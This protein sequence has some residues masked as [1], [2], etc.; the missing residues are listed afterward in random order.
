MLG[1]V[2]MNRAFCL[3]PI[4]RRIIET[5]HICGTFEFDGDLEKI[6]NRMRPLDPRDTRA[7]VCTL[8]GCSARL[9]GLAW[10]ALLQ[11]ERDPGVS[12]QM[13]LGAVAV[14]VQ[15]EPERDGA[16]FESLA[17]KFN[18]AHRRCQ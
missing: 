18:T 17:Q 2:R 14:S 13:E 3:G 15:I 8:A 12:R 9:S 11:I 6:T 7:Q 4:R 1:G 16:F 5:P 10:R